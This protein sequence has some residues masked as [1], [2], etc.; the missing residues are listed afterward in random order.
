MIIPPDPEKDPRLFDARSLASDGD[1]ITL[2]EPSTPGL[3]YHPANAPNV[4]LYD[5]PFSDEYGVNNQWDPLPPYEGRRSATPRGSRLV[6]T[7]SRASGS[8]SQGTLRRIARSSPTVVATPPV[9]E[10]AEENEKPHRPWYTLSAK[11]MWNKH[12][13]W[14]I[15]LGILAAFIIALTIGLVVGFTQG[16]HRQSVEQKKEQRKK[17]HQNPVPNNS[18]WGG[19]PN[20]NI[21]Y[22]SDRDG[23]MPEDGNMAY[24]NQFSPLN[25]SNSLRQLSLSSDFFNHFV[26]TYNFSLTPQN[27]TSRNTT[28]VNATDC[29][30]TLTL[31]HPLYFLARGLASSGTLEFV[32]SNSPDEVI[33]GG[34]E[35]SVR[36]DV[37]ARVPKNRTLDSLARVCHMSRKDG[38]MG[39]GVYT[40]IETDG[41]AD[42]PSYLLNSV[43]TPAFHII[44]RFPPS[45]L[46]NSTVYP[47]PAF[48]GNVSFDLAQMGMRVGNMRNVVQFGDFDVRADT[49]GGG[50]VVDYLAA[51]TARIHGAEGSVQGTFNISSSLAINSTSGTIMAN[52]IL[53]DPDLKLDNSTTV[54]STIPMPRDV[55]EDGS[56]WDEDGNYI[57]TSNTYDDG[58]PS[59]KSLKEAAS[60]AARIRKLQQQPTHE[61]NTTFMTNEGFIFV[62]YLH[63][64]PS[65]ALKSFVASRSGVVDV[66]MHPNYVGPFSLANLW[67]SIRLPP[68]TRPLSDDPLNLG[69]IRRMLTGSISLTNTTFFEA[70]DISLLGANNAAAVA[71]RVTGAALWAF[72]SDDSYTALS[73][74]ESPEARGSAF[75][76]MANLGDLQVTFDGH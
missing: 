43:G 60:R 76:A 28:W 16:M 65:T 36:V 40:P 37:I 35:D 32:G 27:V 29:N 46:K 56:E 63:H 13:K 1:L 10:E 42:G 4:L 11:E 38:S 50:V 71:A 45:I 57:G 70:H 74:Q 52:V 23:P 54:K 26:T 25:N 49:R 19:M 41:G 55:Y 48:I 58:E 44:V 8:S 53:N 72:P 18:W 24:C 59:N 12:R 66:A 3:A 67:G 62:A 64:P 6:A 51:E 5:G 31:P 14:H 73:T 61:V 33:E 34:N 2:D 75:V 30:S 47:S 69:R 17:S 20:L 39:I 7:T 15:G 22:D 21:T 68:I 9:K